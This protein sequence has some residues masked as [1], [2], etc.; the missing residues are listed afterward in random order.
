MDTLRL[1][2]VDDEPHILSA[3]A[4][5]LRFHYRQDPRAIVIDMESDPTRALALIEERAYAV[6]ISDYRMPDLTGVEVLTY[7]RST[8]PQCTRLMLS[9]Q[10]DQDGLTKAINSAQ[11]HRF[12][13]KPWTEGALVDAVESALAQHHA[14][15][16]EVELLD[17]ARS[18]QGEIS[19]QELERRRLERLE[20]GLTRVEFDRD[21][22]YVL[23]P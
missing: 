10:V 7:M 4:R 5:Q 13:A 3:L 18:D 16:V 6:V 11:V 20:P 9:G 23:A 17:R 22:A 21:G 2:L 1:L 8:Q 14:A 15:R 19:P 12:L